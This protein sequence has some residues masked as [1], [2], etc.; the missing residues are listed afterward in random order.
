MLLSLQVS[1]GRS[2]GIVTILELIQR[3]E[4]VTVLKEEATV[5]TRAEFADHS[6]AVTTHIMH[7]VLTSEKL[8]GRIY[9]LL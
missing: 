5:F 9:A 7:A 6:V 3:F 2:V 4:S 1:V 8:S